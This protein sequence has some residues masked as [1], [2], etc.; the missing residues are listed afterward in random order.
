MEESRGQL[1]VT[2]MMSDCHLRLL[3][4]YGKIKERCIYHYEFYE[5]D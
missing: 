3:L 2:D 4:Y 5:R 1:E